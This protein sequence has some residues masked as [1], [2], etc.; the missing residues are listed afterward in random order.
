M[1]I[2]GKHAL[3]DDLD[4]QADAMFRALVLE[5]T[6]RLM[7]RTPVRTARAR[8]NWQIGVGEP[9]LENIPEGD[10]PK[11]GTVSMHQAIQQSTQLAA[12]D[13]AYVTNALPYI[14]A[15]NQ[16]SSKQMPAGWIELTMAELDAIIEQI[17]GIMGRG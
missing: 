5:A 6:R 11:T 2:L 14:P 12:G 15:L 16:G 17:M 7:K 3:L 8:N 4:Q 10:Y 13:V 9:V 1:P